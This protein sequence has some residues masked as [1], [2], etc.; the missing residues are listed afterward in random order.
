[1]YVKQAIFTVLVSTSLT[2]LALP[3]NHDNL[4]G[5][6]AGRDE[7]AA[8]HP[9]YLD[10]MPRAVELDERANLEARKKKPTPKKTTAK[11]TPTPVKT[12][13]KTTP[14]VEK[15]SS[16]APKVT[17][18]SE[19]AKPT[20]TSSAKVEPSTSEKPSTSPEVVPSTSSVKEVPS[21]SSLIASDTQ[22]K[23][24]ATLSS[25]ALSSS[26]VA[27]D[28]AIPSSVGVTSSA[29]ALS[30]T[31]P[32]SVTPGT[33]AS[34]S[35]ISS[36][37]E[38]ITT[39]PTSSAGEP[40]NTSDPNQETSDPGSGFTIPDLD[41][42]SL[43]G[44]GT[45][46]YGDFVSSSTTD[47]AAIPTGNA[48][49]VTGDP[50]VVAETLGASGIVPAYSSSFATDVAPQ[51]TATGMAIARRAWANGMPQLVDTTFVTS[52]TRAAA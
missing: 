23:S 22:I 14:A 52:T 36:E 1:M 15:T 10:P 51:V 43:I 46:L 41:Y 29:P 12:T 30:E 42:G 44:V 31:A 5:L 39:S 3:G 16:V 6:K 8:R 11:E 28:T 37:A 38:T 27:S 40:E 7:I 4:P 24:S 35:S 13:A 33:S 9:S 50:T 48:G 19:A 21:S 34:L 49:V 47:L 25:S 32:A 17:S 18:T 26:L 20:T 2:V 45:S